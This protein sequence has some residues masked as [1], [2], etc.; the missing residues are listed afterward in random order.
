MPGFDRNEL[1]GNRRIILWGMNIFKGVR[2]IFVA[3]AH[4]MEDTIFSI[5]CELK[6]LEGV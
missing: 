1:L 6:K 4:K 5:M 2:C 3:Q